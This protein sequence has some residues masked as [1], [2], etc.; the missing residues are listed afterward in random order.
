MWTGR[1]GESGSGLWT[2]YWLYLWVLIWEVQDEPQSCHGNSILDSSVLTS[3]DNLLYGAPLIY[4]AELLDQEWKPA[5]RCCW[6]S[7]YNEDDNVWSLYLSPPVPSVYI[8]CTKVWQS[9]SFFVFFLPGKKGQLLLNIHQCRQLMRC[10]FTFP[11]KPE[12]PGTTHSEPESNMEL[13]MCALWEK[14]AEWSPNFDIKRNF[15]RIC[16]DLHHTNWITK[17]EYEQKCWTRTNSGWLA[18][19]YT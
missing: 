7:V 18:C 2:G 19:C 6:G 15:G 11:I 5:A 10:A 1:C 17:I 8:K 4:R 3:D 9:Q 12:M 13:L 16:T 14:G